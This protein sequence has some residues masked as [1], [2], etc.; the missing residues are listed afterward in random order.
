MTKEGSQSLQRRAPDK[1]I[2][3]AK[4]PFHVTANQC[5]PTDKGLEV[6]PGSAVVAAG[7]NVNCTDSNSVD[8]AHLFPTGAGYA[9]TIGTDFAVIKWQRILSMMIYTRR[10]GASHHCLN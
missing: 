5:W 8:T 9:S 1:Y 2:G 3:Q 4:L 7:W 10:V 6:G